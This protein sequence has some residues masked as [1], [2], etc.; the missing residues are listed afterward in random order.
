M[1]LKKLSLQ[2]SKFVFLEL[3]H[4]HSEFSHGSTLNGVL[5]ICKTVSVFEACMTYNGVNILSFLHIVQEEETFSQLCDVN[6]IQI[7]NC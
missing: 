2:V 3:S 6:Y 1:S 4:E 7:Y 5:K